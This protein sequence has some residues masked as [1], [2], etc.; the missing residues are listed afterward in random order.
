MQEYTK[1]KGQEFK[2]DF[3]KRLHDE[4]T[5]IG[6]KASRQGQVASNSFFWQKREAGIR[7]LTQF[8]DELCAAEKKALQSQ[9]TLPEGYFDTLI[10]D[11]VILSEPIFEEIKKELSNIIYASSFKD[12]TELDKEKELINR[13]T[14]KV[15]ILQEDIKIDYSQIS[16]TPLKKINIPPFDFIQIK[17]LITILKRDYQEVLICKETECWKASIIL[18][19]SLIEGI[20]YDLLKQNEARALE[21][22]GAQKDKDGKILPL[23]DWSLTY[24]INTAANLNLIETGIKGLHHATKDYRNL[25]HPTNEIKSSYKLKKEEADNA[26]AILNMLI[27][28]L[29]EV[30]NKKG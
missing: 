3:V 13:I 5:K 1:L 14:H 23:E 20:L 17:E 24:L 16:K 27:R 21:S 7:I 6:V 11:F 19:G 8:I 10:K 25:V 28:D 15:K 30:W 29:T 12:L 2:D 4:W 26:F 9:T 18:C 22:T